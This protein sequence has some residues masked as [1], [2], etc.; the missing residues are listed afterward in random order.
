MI[1]LLI[2]GT[3][4][5][6]AANSDPGFPDVS[7]MTDMSDLQITELEDDDTEAAPNIIGNFPAC[8]CCLSD[9]LIRARKFGKLRKMLYFLYSY[10][11]PKVILM[12]V[13]ELAIITRPRLNSF[14]LCWTICRSLRLRIRS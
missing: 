11:I 5:H 14:K 6:N 10:N 13:N 12:P 3:S 2:L 9:K 8:E 7:G 4:T 1:N